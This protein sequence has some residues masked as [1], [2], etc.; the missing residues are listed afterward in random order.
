MRCSHVSPYLQ[1]LNLTLTHSPTHPLTHS[2]T[3]SLTH[4]LIH[5][6]IHE[7]YIIGSYVSYAKSPIDGN[8]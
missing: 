5:I 2:L 1:V 4:S 6:E 8:Q 7:Y 3:P